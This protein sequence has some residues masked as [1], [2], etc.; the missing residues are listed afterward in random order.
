M[1]HVSTL[2]NGPLTS[3]SPT[4]KHHH[5][6][7]SYSGPLKD[8]TNSSSTHL[9]LDP[10]AEKKWVRM[11]R[12]N[13]NPNDEPLKTSLGKRTAQSSLE[14]TQPL[15]RIAIRDDA[16]PRKK[17][18]WKGRRQDGFVLERLDCAVANNLWL[19]KNPG[20]KVQ[21]LHS[22][23]S[24]H[25]AIVVK[26][27]GI[28]PKPKRSFKFEQMWL[29][30]RGCSDTVLNAWG[31]PLV[32]ATM[33][34]IVGKVQICG[35]KLSE[36]SKNFFS[37]VRRLLEEKKLLLT[38]AELAAAKGG[39]TMLVKSLQLEING[40]LDKE[41]Q[42]WQQ[43]SRAL[44]LKCGDRNTAYF[45]S[46]ASQSGARVSTLID[47]IN[48]CW[49]AEVVDSNF[50][51]HDANMIK[52]IPLS[53]M[54]SDDILCWPSNMDGKYSV[55]SR[56]RLLVNEELNSPVD[57]SFL[58]QSKNTWRGLWKLRIPNRIKNLLWRASKEALLT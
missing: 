16:L 34:E 2:Q 12:P 22:N 28:I 50:S 57:S 53:I 14:N 35:E 47:K 30:D 52:S 27:E 4:T 37:S 54:E 42:M 23:S 40:I 39:D 17:F 26:P 19:S 46:K 25:Q 55:K 8:I 13:Y 3:N 58:P 1:D 56:Y 29:Q 20:T 49:S 21:H 38:K 6:E 48:R 9:Q 18:T 43:R 44:F 5:T 45:H 10:D 11:K 51:A 15:K 41:S 32:G 31:P 7:P 36:W 24:D 33:P